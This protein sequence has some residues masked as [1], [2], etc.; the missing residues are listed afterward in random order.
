MLLGIKGVADMAYFPFTTL[1]PL[2]G[3]PA[4]GFGFWK[5]KAAWNGIPPLDG[6]S[7]GLPF[8]VPKSCLT[9]RCDAGAFGSTNFRG[10]LF[11]ILLM[12]FS[13]SHIP[14]IQY[15]GW[16][17][18]QQGES[19]RRCEPPNIRQYHAPSK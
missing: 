9:L 8:P 2:Q 13:F 3:T 5:L 12:S 17:K 14:Y 16:Y 15:H 4:P 11:Q 18:N 19:R 1:F 6:L 7:S 10:A